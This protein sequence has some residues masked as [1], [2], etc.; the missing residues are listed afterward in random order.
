MRARKSNV[1]SGSGAGLPGR[2]ALPR[3]AEPG[4]E[5]PAGPSVPDE[6][7]GRRALRGL[8]G[9]PTCPSDEGLP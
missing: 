1:E 8:Q 7:Q 3:R 4:H 9:Q 6:E 2:P 5:R